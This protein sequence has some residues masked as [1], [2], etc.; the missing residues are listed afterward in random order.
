VNGVLREINMKLALTPEDWRF[1]ILRHE[2]RLQQRDF[3]AIAAVRGCHW[4]R[5]HKSEV[6]CV[7]TDWMASHCFCSATGTAHLMGH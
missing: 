4:Y 3:K 5:F 2:N 7:R 6:R 1:D